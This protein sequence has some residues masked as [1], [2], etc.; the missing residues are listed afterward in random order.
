[1]NLSQ[2]PVDFIAVSAHKFH[3]PKGAGFMYVKNRAQLKPLIHGGSQERELRAGTE[4]IHNIVGLQKAME[5]AYA[6]L[7]KEA[8]LYQI[9]KKLFYIN[10]EG[11]NS[12]YKI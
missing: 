10:I 1:M 5:L 9:F 6:N 2:L 7:E 3:G 8:N 11:S 12:W 4:S